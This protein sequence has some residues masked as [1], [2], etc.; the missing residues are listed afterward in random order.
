MSHRIRR[1]RT[2][3]MG[4][5]VEFRRSNNQQRYNDTMTKRK[6]YLAAL[7]IFV[8]FV[9]YNTIGDIYR[10]FKANRLSDAIFAENI[11]EVQRL[12][13]EGVDPLWPNF[14]RAFDTLD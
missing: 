3:G 12:L 14:S 4:R 8:A 10:T 9:A 6:L 7:T 11:V 5:R 13:E 1:L 2:S